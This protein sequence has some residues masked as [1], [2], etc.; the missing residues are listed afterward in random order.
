M[1]ITAEP[2]LPFLFDFLDE[3]LGEVYGGMGFLGRFYPLSIEISSREIASIIANNN[4]IDIEH[5]HYLEHEVVS[6]IFGSWV[7]AQQKL[8]DVL[9][10]IGSHGLSWMDS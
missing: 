9:N 8:D 6:Q 1:D 4:P 2:Q 10:Y 5:G 7:I 3:H